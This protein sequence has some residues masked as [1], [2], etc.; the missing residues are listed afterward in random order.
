MQLYVKSLIVNGMVT[1][2]HEVIFA[3]SGEIR[4]N[5]DAIAAICWRKDYAQE[6][7]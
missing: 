2:Q 4:A 3:Y 7:V 1:R 6:L 5:D